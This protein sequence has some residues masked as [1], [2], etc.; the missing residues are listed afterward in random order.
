[1]SSTANTTAIKYKISNFKS[2]FAGCLLAFGIGQLLAFRELDV[3]DGE[4]REHRQRQNRRP[5]QQESEHDQDEA[6]ILRMSDV[7]VS[8]CR[9]E[10]VPALCVI[11]HLPRRRQKK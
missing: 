6:D 2:R 4:Y 1:M 10:F 5:L 7:A 8:S 11:E 9:R 3:H